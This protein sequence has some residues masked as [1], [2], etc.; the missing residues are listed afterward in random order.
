MKQKLLSALLMSAFAGV[1]TTASAGVIQASYK[2]YAAEVFGSNAVVLTAPT[3]SYA[4]A[5]PLSGTALNP[6]QFNI[7]WTLSDGEWAAAPAVGFIQLVRPDNSL[8][9]NPDSVTLS[10]DKKTLTAAFTVA[11][12]Y[13]TSSQI[14][15]GSGGAVQITKIGD[16]L[17]APAANSCGND[18]ASV[19]VT[20]KLANAAGSEFESNFA[21]APLKNTESIARSAMALSLTA[22]SSAK[23]PRTTGG[24][25]AA[26]IESARVDV[27]NPSLGTKF[28][29]DGDITAA[30]TTTINLG[31]LVIADKSTLFDLGGSAAYS[32]TDANWGVAANVTTGRVEASNLTFKVT[33]KFGADGTVDVKANTV[34]NG[35][36][37]VGAT[38]NPTVTFNADRTEATITI[39]NAGVQAATLSGGKR[40]LHIEYTVPGTK[41][42][43]VAQFKIASGTLNKDSNALEVANS[44]CPGD[45]YTLVANGVQLDVRNY[46]PAIVEAPSGGWK[47]VIRIINT[48]ENQTSVDVIGQA[49]LRDGT[50]GAS[51]IIAAA[52]KPRE[53]RYLS[54]ASIDAVLNAA[55][56][57]TAKTFG[58]DDIAANA[59]LR[60]S[61]AS[62]SIRVQ[63]YHFNPATGNYLEASSA[64]GDEGPNYSANGDTKATNR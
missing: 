59:R 12:N 22:L 10:T 23:F 20:V 63:N 52:M 21:L 25:L 60:I 58:A 16:K 4:L 27:L 19:S 42:V 30:S 57:A 15:L 38:V 24:S 5:T 56:T 32:V 8:S 62:A 48:D 3:I 50:L 1:A 37:V 41:I 13:T 49:I 36:Y 44:V 46:I 33:G 39:A 53:V 55:A 43:P 2:N 7:S 17:G 29:N 31:A 47:N 34:V 14:V 64:Q 51:G 61:A 18:E 6:N 35:H 28:T 40:I 45:I 26:D 11:A 54:A 9:L